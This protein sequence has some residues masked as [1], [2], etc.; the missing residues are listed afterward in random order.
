MVKFQ[1]FQASTRF[2]VQI[3]IE[4]CY[5]FGLNETLP[6]VEENSNC[7]H[8]NAAKIFEIDTDLRVVMRDIGMIFEAQGTSVRTRT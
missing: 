8:R 7:L 3:V 1:Y 2:A 6:A 4:N 5:Q